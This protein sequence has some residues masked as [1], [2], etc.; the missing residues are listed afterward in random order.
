MCYVSVARFEG[1]RVGLLPLWTAATYHHFLWAW[2][3]V[4]LAGQTIPA[5]HEMFL[6]RYVLMYAR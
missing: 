6:C 2:V 3:K 5:L 4:T 1:E